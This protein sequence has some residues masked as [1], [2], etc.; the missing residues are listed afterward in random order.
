MEQDGK[1]KLKLR[2]MFVWQ[3]VKEFFIFFLPKRYNNIF[4]IFFWIL[5]LKKI[6]YKIST[7]KIYIIQNRIVAFLLI[8]DLYLLLP[9][10]SYEKQKNNKKHTHIYTH[11]KD[12]L[13]KHKSKHKANRQ[14]PPDSE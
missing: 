3:N 8:A 5:N 4:F 1:Q 11:N 14:P 7:Q 10:L 2:V 6:K 9:A 13:S 12:I